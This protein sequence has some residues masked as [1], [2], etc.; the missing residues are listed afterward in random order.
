M[1]TRLDLPTL[2]P[3][4]CGVTTRT[5]DELRRQLS[6]L[7]GTVLE[8]G[9][10]A[11]VN[12]PFFPPE[13]RWIGVEPDRAGREA[14]TRV[15]DRLGRSAELIDGRAEDLD[16][17][18]GSVDAVVG[19]YVLCS[20]ED[21]RGAV[22][23]VRRVLRPGGLYLFAEHV[24][25][26]PGSWTRR[27]QHL[28]AMTRLRAGRC[29]PNRD[30]EAVIRSAGFAD[31]SVGHGTLPGPLGT[32]IPQIV[33]SARTA[34]ARPRLGADHDMTDNPDIPEEN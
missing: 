24:A 5:A 7:R 21:Q 3:L 2:P 16:L 9:P 8:I 18:S 31:V 25:A 26:P 33:G 19:T 14:T 13:V 23:E 34:V 27:A 4:P 10:G 28:M 29:R 15:A 6:D 32:R 22:A 30:T 20:V 12:L 1:T 17:L 11:G